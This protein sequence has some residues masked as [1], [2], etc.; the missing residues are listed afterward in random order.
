MFKEYDAVRHHLSI[1]HRYEILNNN[2]HFNIY[3]F[4]PNEKYNDNKIKML[5]VKKK[6]HLVIN[7][8]IA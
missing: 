8:H 4:F 5:F 1:S 6:S 3:I 2:F 7:A